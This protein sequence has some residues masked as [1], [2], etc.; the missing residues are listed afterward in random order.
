MRRNFKAKWRRGSK[1]SAQSMRI[2]GDYFKTNYICARPLSRIRGFRGSGSGSAIS[3]NRF[4]QI[5]HYFYS[6]FSNM[7][8]LKN[9]PQKVK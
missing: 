4:S 3:N 5:D 8:F 6:R 2:H 1:F 9:P 7:S